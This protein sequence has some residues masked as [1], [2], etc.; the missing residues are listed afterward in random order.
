MKAQSKVKIIGG[1]PVQLCFAMRKNVNK[2]KKIELDKNQAQYAEEE[3]EDDYEALTARK[4]LVKK[5][6]KSKSER[7]TPKFDVGKIAVIRNLPADAKEKRILK[8]CERFGA[9]ESVNYPVSSDEP[10][11]AHVTFD[12]HRTARLAIEGLKDTRY[13]K[14][15]DQVMSAVLLSKDYKPVSTKTLKK[16]RLIVRNLSFSCSEEDVKQIFEKFGAVV[17]VH[18][19]RKENSY[20]RG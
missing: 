16:S 5:S 2:S 19:P 18:I 10:H 6:H 12:S 3:E 20:M 11:T 15:Y 7:T 1:R 14:K 9:V 8:R 17:D 13:K 4:E